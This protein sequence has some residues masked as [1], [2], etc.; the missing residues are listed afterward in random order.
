MNLIDNELFLRQL[1]QNFIS[2]NATA[3]FCYVF[4]LTYQILVF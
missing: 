3:N 1:L 4:V 2:C